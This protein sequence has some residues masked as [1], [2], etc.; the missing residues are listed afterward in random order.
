MSNVNVT[1]FH[2]AIPLGSLSH[3]GIVQGH[4]ILVYWLDFNRWTVGIFRLRSL[5]RGLTATGT[6]HLK[7]SGLLY[8]N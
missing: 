7:P 5:R 4:R 3:A 2:R 1:I 6:H 8:P